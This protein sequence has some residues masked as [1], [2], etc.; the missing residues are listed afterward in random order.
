VV[1]QSHSLHRRCLLGLRIAVGILL[2]A[3]ALF[4]IVYAMVF[5][6]RGRAKDVP[7]LGHMRFIK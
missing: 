5:A 6:A 7:F 3:V 1:A 2:A 4:Y